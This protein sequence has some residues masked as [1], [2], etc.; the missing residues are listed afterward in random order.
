[1]E[2]I[3]LILVV[4][5]V[6]YWL[7]GSDTKKKAKA[8]RKRR[9]IVRV[10]ERKESSNGITFKIDVDD[11]LLYEC[12]I[13]KYE[14][15]IEVRGDGNFH[16]QYNPKT[17]RWK[18]NEGPY[19]EYRPQ[20]AKLLRDEWEKACDYFGTP[21]VRHIPEKVEPFKFTQKEIDL[22][23]DLESLK[24][25]P[26]K[27]HAEGSQGQKYEM[28]L[29]ILECSCPD[30]LKRR[31]DFPLGDVRR[32]CKHQAKSIFKLKKNNIITED[33]R[34]QTLVGKAASRGWGVPL[35]KKIVEFEIDDGTNEK[36]T[37]F[38]VIPEG[39]FEW[40]DVF[41]FGKG[42]YHRYG[43]NYKAMRWAQEL[44]PYPRGKQ[45][46]YNMTLKRVIKKYL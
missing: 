14:S 42:R 6:L 30:F 26:E 3:V 8:K 34:I 28:Y 27:Y 41:C 29:S 7:F 46:R 32:I 20:I 15:S 11:M 43:Y 31:K 16:Y 2:T 23:Y 44:H 1:M 13:S 35:Y 37:S 5:F 38:V 21:V 22:V 24:E 39:D 17:Y 10:I 25:L 45:R 36:S 40:L 19:D 9:D 4:I 33:L 12:T 18:N